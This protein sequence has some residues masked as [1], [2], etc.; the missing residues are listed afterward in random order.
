[1]VEP[2]GGERFT[3]ILGSLREGGRLAIVAFT[4]GLIPEVKINRLLVSNAEVLG[5]E[6][7]AH[8]MSGLQRGREIVGALGDLIERGLISP[9]IGA[10]YPLSGAAGALREVDERRATGKVILDVR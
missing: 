10:R 2:V 1:M 8:V 6:W 9:I 3:E 5:A 4:R 7:G